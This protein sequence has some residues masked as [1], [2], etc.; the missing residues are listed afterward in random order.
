MQCDTGCIL[1][2]EQTQNFISPGFTCITVPGST[3]IAPTAVSA[4]V[5][6]TVTIVRKLIIPVIDGTIL[7]LCIQS[8]LCIFNY[9]GESRSSCHGGVRLV[10]G[11]NARARE[12]RVMTTV[13]QR[14]VLCVHS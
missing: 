8:L 12:G 3:N 1:K 6:I 13:T 9:R 7:I 2:D 10:N 14:Q 11:A 4:S 5:A